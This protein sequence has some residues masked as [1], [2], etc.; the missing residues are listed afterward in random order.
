MI[1]NS[2]Y[3][4]D[5]FIKFNKVLFTYSFNFIIKITK[6]YSCQIIILGYTYKTI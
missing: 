4:W 2:N 6:F 3:C 1:Y 5:L